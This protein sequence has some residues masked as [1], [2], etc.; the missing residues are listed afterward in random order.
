MMPWMIGSA[1][2]FYGIFAA[3]IGSIFIWNAWK[4]LFINPKDPSFGN[5]KK[6]FVYSI[7]Y[8]FWIFGAI[9]IDT[10]ILSLV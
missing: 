4:V 5:E 7:K 10:I 8:L 6:L 3:S 2:F 9:L 1:S